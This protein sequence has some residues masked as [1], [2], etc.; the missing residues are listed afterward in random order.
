MRR[1]FAVAIIGGLIIT[2]WIA[3]VENQPAPTQTPAKQA[4][5]PARV[6]APEIK[7]IGT[8][9]SSYGMLQGSFTLKN[10]NDFAIAD[11][12]IA[13]SVTAP[14]GTVIHR[15]DFIIYETLQ[16]NAT[17]TVRNYKFGLWPQQGK[18]ISCRSLGA[19]RY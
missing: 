13:C 1:F 3:A 17:K 16:P 4:N 7:L 6:Q 14:S 11:A 10:L 9:D 8:L 12:Q 15:Y 19:L 5:A 18:S 2:A